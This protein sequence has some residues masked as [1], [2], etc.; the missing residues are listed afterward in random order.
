VSTY[1]GVTVEHLEGDEIDP[2]EVFKV[3]EEHVDLDYFDGEQPHRG[4]DRGV[5]QKHVATAAQ[6][7]KYMVDGDWA[8]ASEELGPTIRLV[9]YEEWNDDDPGGST[10]TYI[11][12]TQ[13]VDQS[14][15]KTDVNDALLAVLDVTKPPEVM[16]PN[17]QGVVL[18]WYPAGTRFIMVPP[19]V[20][21]TTP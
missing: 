1:T 15:T 3:L 19:K 9:V 8:K 7:G 18:G 14:F 6:Y 20:V 11:G 10:C 16:E 4:Y 5:P 21:P 2:E 13:I 12:G 17:A